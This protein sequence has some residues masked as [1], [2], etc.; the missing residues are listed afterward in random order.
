M[1]KDRPF[2]KRRSLPAMVIFLV[3][4]V[5]TAKSL[6]AQEDKPTVF[7]HANLI[8]MT[9]ETVLPDQTVVVHGK[10][11]TAVGSG[12]RITV[13][14]NA[15]VIDCNHA[16]LIPGLADMHMHLRDNWMS[17]AWPVSPLNLYLA[18]GVTTIRC[19]GPM[20]GSGQYALAWRK[21]IEK[22]MPMTIK[23]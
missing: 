15:T 3:L 23:R 19:F 9:S 13:P 5:L 21:D 2:M 18:N 20:G 10:Q 1:T 17:D 11:I 14:P 16:Y 7:I 6:L 12:N 4:W 8:P 22:I